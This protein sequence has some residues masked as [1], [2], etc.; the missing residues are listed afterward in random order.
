MFST[1]SK[2]CYYRGGGE[3][4]KEKQ[5]KKQHYSCFS[6]P[7]IYIRRLETACVPDCPCDTGSLGKAGDLLQSLHKTIPFNHT[8]AALSGLSLCGGGIYFS[9]IK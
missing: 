5:K 6:V 9:S 4:R 3:E 1:K 8:E 7:R 2:M